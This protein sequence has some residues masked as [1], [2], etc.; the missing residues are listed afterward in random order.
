MTLF[1]INETDKRK[2]K[3]GKAT[4]GNTF[5]RSLY[6]HMLQVTKTK[7]E[8]DILLLPTDLDID[9]HKNLLCLHLI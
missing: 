7:Y 4:E 5:Y 3:E 8:G 6:Q 1:S 9:L 2:W